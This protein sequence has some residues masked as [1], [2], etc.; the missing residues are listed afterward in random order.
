MRYFTPKEDS[1]VWNR[2]AQISTNIFYAPPKFILGGA[3]CRRF[4]CSSVCPSVHNFCPGYFSAT[5]DRNSMKL[6]GKFHYQEEM[7]I[8]SAGSGW[9]IFHRFMALWNF[10][11]TVHNSAILVQAISQ[12]LM[13]GIQWNFMGSFTTKRTCAYYQRVL[14][15]WFFTE[16]WPFEIFH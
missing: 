15:K 1:F 7:C 14:V 4:F 10:P 12:Q 9:M 2:H 13:T 6:Y 3:Y 11:W 16:L 5:H 8:L